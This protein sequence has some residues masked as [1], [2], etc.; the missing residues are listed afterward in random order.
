VVRA[1]LVQYVYSKRLSW[2]N[3]PLLVLLQVVDPDV[4]LGAVETRV[5]PLHHL[6]DLAD[7]F[8]YSTHVN[9]LILA[10]QL[11]ENGANVNAVSSP[12]GMTP[13]HTACS[14]ASVT[15]LEFVE[16]LLE[17][18]A[19]PNWCIRPALLQVQPNFC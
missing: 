19:D 3:S 13:L 8:D 4:L 17:A 15:N 11:V 18:G 9:Q 16:L 2:P 7:P 14:W 12:Q 5:S 10:K 1:C 6:A